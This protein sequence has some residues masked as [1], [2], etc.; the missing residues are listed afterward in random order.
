MDSNEALVLVMSVFTVG[1]LVG[2]IIGM[3][4]CSKHH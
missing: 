4:H 2:Y 3:W 1:A